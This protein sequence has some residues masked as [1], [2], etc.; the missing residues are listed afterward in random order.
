MQWFGR[1]RFFLWSPGHPVS[2]SCSQGPFQGSQLQLFSLSNSCSTISLVLWQCSVICH[3]LR[4]VYFCFVFVF[5]FVFLFLFFC[6]LFFVRF[7][8]FRYEPTKS[9]RLQV[10]FTLIINTLSR[11]LVWIEWY[12]C[13]SKS[14][15]ILCITCSPRDSCLSLAQFLVD[16]LSHPVVHS[17][18]FL[19]RQF[20]AF[21]HY[22]YDFHYM[23]MFF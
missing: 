6:F 15:G 23:Q 8:F 13:I 20:T 14:Q 18:E 16:R 19:L 5:V 22:Y 12:L 10:L 2:F 1:S 9:S 4:F 3:I 7:F 21:A 11:L 17:L